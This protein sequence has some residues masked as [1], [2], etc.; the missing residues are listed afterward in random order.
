MKLWR[1]MEQAEFYNFKKGKFIRPVRDIRECAND[2]DTNGMSFFGTAN[3]AAHWS[4]P[5]TGNTYIVCLEVP[6]GWVKKGVGNYPDFH[7]DPAITSVKVKEYQI[8][9]YHRSNAK[10][11][12]YGRRKWMS[13]RE[14]VVILKNGELL[15][16][17]EGYDD[18]AE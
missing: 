16:V 2:W 12:T 10:L 1:A 3:N 4:N 14:S 9:W 7:K 15:P 11:V 5:L 13:G 8:P 18:I 6:D 17:L